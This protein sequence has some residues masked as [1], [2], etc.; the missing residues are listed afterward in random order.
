M[1]N[2]RLKVTVER[3][4]GGKRKEQNEQHRKHR[5][6]EKKTKDSPMEICTTLKIFNRNTQLETAV[7]MF[8][9]ADIRKRYERW[10]ARQKL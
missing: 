8:L 5:E 9:L 7:L 1:V 10:L 3:G 2:L 4:E 6:K